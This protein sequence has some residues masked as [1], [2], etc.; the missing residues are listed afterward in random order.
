MSELMNEYLKQACGSVYAV[1]SDR[2]SD[3]DHH[4]FCSGGGSHTE[5]DSHT[6][7]DW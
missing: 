7:S 2:H 4:D 3:C 5:Y 6:D 1:H